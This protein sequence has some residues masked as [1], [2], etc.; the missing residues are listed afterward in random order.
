M[1]FAC[2]QLVLSYISFIL[3]DP[4]YYGVKSDDIGTVEG[5]VA[6]QGEAFVIITSLITGP[7]LD[8]VGRKIPVILGYLVTGTAI[9]S[10][11]FFNSIYPSFFILRTLICMGT[12]IGLNLP[13]LPDYVHKGSLGLANAYNEVVISI[14]F[15]LASTGLYAINDYISDQK[16]VYFGFGGSIIAISLFL[17]YGIKDIH[18]KEDD[19]V[20][21]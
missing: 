15:I 19:Q 5:N 4:N 20:E 21:E 18:W 17:I 7:I 13:L 11:P 3:T 14:S 8:T 9:F 16:Y 1:C 6:Y 2:L 12:V 10:I